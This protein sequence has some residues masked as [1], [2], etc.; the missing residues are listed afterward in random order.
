[1]PKDAPREKFYA[2]SAVSKEQ[3]GQTYSEH[4]LGRSGVVTKSVEFAIEASN[5]HPKLKDSFPKVV[6]AAAY[7][8]DLGKLLPE[9][10]AVLSGSST[11][12]SLPSNHVDAGAAYLKRENCIEGAL[13]VYSHH[14]GLPDIKKEERHRISWY[15]HKDQED[16]E[17]ACEFRDRIDSVLDDLVLDHCQSV[18]EQNPEYLQLNLT[19]LGRRIALSCLV[20]AD[21]SDTA[22][23][24]SPPDDLE[25]PNLTPT[26]RLESLKAYVGKLSR[27]SEE[28][29]QNQTRSD[30]FNYCAKFSTKS[31]ILECDAPVGSGKTTSVVAH[32]LKVAAERKLGRI[33]VVLPFTNIID[34]S[35]EILRKALVL[36]GE[37][38]EAVVMAHHHRAEFN[39]FRYRGYASTWNA[40]IVVT[41]AVQFFEAISACHTGSLRKLHRL[42]NSAVMVDEAHTAI[43]IELWGQHWEWLQE[44][45]RDWGS[46]FVLASGSLVKFWSMKEA[47]ERPSS[48]LSLVPDNLSAQ[49][50]KIDT[51]RVTLRSRSEK[52]TSLDSLTRFISDTPGPRVVVM[53]TVQ[54]AATV[55][56]HLAESFGRASVIHLSTA[57]CP[58]D[59]VKIVERIKLRLKNHSDNNWFLVATSCI[60][61]G[62]NFSFQ[63]GFRERSSLLS[64]IQLGGRV[65]RDGDRKDSILWDFEVDDPELTKFEPLKGSRSVTADFAKKGQFSAEFSSEFI[66]TILTVQ[67]ISLKEAAKKII[68]LESQLNYPEVE[69]SCRVINSDSKTVIIDFH[70]FERLKNFEKVSFREIQESSV[71][72]FTNFKK[73]NLFDIERL[74]GR[75]DIYVWKHEYSPDFL[76]YM[77]GY[78][79]LEKSSRIGFE[80][81]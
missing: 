23:F 60:E 22:N 26:E 58:R 80:I 44:L 3:D 48:L 8:H 20:D 40:P 76:G 15:R 27:A 65:N 32:L 41:T 55:A 4:L 64:T 30:W 72:M 69:K 16:I 35:V 12:K 68:K 31:S 74:P 56:L 6:E 45:C 49:F 61:A 62:M 25:I 51:T 24:Y 77:E 36:P 21:H 67:G 19:G 14:R 28:T 47:V 81:I 75:S 13:L 2:H 38:P 5:R 53:N 50:K 54:N 59:R 33:F 34:Q 73:F 78:L 37:N 39:D 42:C 18:G 70:V 9:N 57:L 10:Q 1:V 11:K 43:P 79:R 52:F 29:L 17:K 66:R 71:Q 63:T 7:F 46:H